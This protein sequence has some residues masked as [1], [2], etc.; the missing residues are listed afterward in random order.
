MI[1]LSK[2]YPV[3]R[4]LMAMLKLSETLQFVFGV[5]VL[6]STTLISSCGSSDRVTRNN[7]SM[8]QLE[9]LMATENFEIRSNWAMPMATTSLNSL[10]SAGL[11]PPGSSAGL[12]NLIGNSNYVRIMGDSL[13]LFL[14]YFGERQMGGGYNSD[15]PGIEFNGI[16]EKM[17]VSK[18]ED[19]Q[20]YDIRLEMTDTSENFQLNLSLFPNHNSTINVTSSH[21]FPIQYSGSVQAIRSDD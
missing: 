14:P 11:L 2:G 8:Q 3:S 5:A 16:P 15:G 18:N 21:R 1:F 4:Y 13:S 7:H 20:R 17:E 9:A 6:V 10:A 19:K 12:I